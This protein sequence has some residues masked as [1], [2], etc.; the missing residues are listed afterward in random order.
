M[1]T[2]QVVSE[3]LG[4]L[5]NVGSGLLTGKNSKVSHSRGKED[6]FREINTP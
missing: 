2:S 4:Q 5:P 1:I 3:S 6:L